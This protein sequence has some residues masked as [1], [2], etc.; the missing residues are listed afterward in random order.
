MLHYKNGT[1]QNYIVYSIDTSTELF[2]RYALV[3]HDAKHMCYTEG[4]RG[5]LIMIDN[6]EPYKLRFRVWLKTRLQ[7]LGL[8]Q[9]ALASA[10]CVKPSTVS[11]WVNGIH[12]PSISKLTDVYCLLSDPPPKWVLNLCT[13]KNQ[14]LSSIPSTEDKYAAEIT[15]R[16]LAAPPDYQKV[17]LMLLE[18]AEHRSTETPS[19]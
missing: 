5:R 15:R 4:E 8:T 6:K 2:F 18:M 3:T 16:Y 11:S 7:D 13:K 1:C 12:Y 19:I 17:I 14:E 9:T 10:L